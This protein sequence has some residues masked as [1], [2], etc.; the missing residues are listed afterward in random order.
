[1]SVNGTI[2]GVSLAFKYRN[3]VRIAAMVP[4]GSFRNGSNVVDVFS[5]EGTGA[6]RRLTRLDTERSSGYQ[7]VER[8]GRT[9][10][11]T[12]AQRFPVVRGRLDGFADQVEFRQGARTF[13]VGGWALDRRAR[14]PV[15]TIVVF[16]ESRF[17]TYGSPTLRRPD[18]SQ[19]V[20]GLVGVNLGF[21]LTPTARGVDPSKV[22]V[23]AISGAEASELRVVGPPSPSP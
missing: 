15:D 5:I 8:S 10:L 23:F 13:R 1:M 22:R 18:V 19:N 17:L 21:R 3:G 20:R 9:Q 16:N 11:T 2:R 7:L 6:G 4:P 14:S 12:R